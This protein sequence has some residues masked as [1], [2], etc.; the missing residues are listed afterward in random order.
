M[1]TRPI[2]IWKNIKDVGFKKQPPR[3]FV[4]ILNRQKKEKGTDY[5]VN[6]STCKHKRVYSVSLLRDMSKVS[7]ENY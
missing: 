7:L 5:E 3:H 2:Q 1:R 6:K 4:W